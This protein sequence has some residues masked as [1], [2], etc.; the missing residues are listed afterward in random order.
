VATGSA[1]LT[2]RDAHEGEALAVACQLFQEYAASLDISLCFQG[3]DEELA[4][5]PGKYAPPRG[6]LLLA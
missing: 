4:T 1:L 6:R 3:F 5:L 2:I